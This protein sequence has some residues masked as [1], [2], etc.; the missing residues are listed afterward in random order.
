MVRQC[1]WWTR[2]DR[3][4]PWYFAHHLPFLFCLGEAGKK[5]IC[6]FSLFL[7]QE[8]GEKMQFSAK[9]R[10]PE[11]VPAPHT[12]LA[13]PGRGPQERWRSQAG[14]GCAPG[15]ATAGRRAQIPES[16]RLRGLLGA[17]G[18]AW[19]RRG[20]AMGSNAAYSRRGA[21]EARR[22]E[23]RRA[24]VS[25]AEVRRGEA[26]RREAAVDGTGRRVGPGSQ[27]PRCLETANTAPA[28]LP[29]GG[30]GSGSRRRPARRQG[31]MPPAWRRRGLASPA[32]P[33]R[34]AACEE[35]G[36]AA[37]CFAGPYRAFL[38]RGG[39]SR[40]AARRRPRPRCGP[41]GLACRRASRCAA[42]CFDFACAFLSFS[43]EAVLAAKGMA[44]EGVA[45]KRNRYLGKSKPGP[46]TLGGTRWSELVTESGKLCLWCSLR[47]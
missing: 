17:A 34:G 46:L 36:P 21:P 22:R 47:F 5:K 13:L 14:G 25:W 35:A 24:E 41:S 6:T 18:R 31:A 2:G 27:A 19:G 15:A 23:A 37:A 33:Q 45:G 44:L 9:T 12:W 42:D 8:A 26:R 4:A 16:G 43:W 30:Q 20:P 7:P 39:R 38:P 28:P 3:I 11:C 10:A 40:P 32:A 1:W 29:A